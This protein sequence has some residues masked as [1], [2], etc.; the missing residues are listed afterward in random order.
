MNIAA[1]GLED[2]L[3]PVLERMRAA[4]AAAPMPGADERRDRLARLES[5]LTTNEHALVKAMSA[6]FAHRSADECRLFDI[7]VPLGGIRFARRNLHRWMRPRRVTTPLHLRPAKSFLQPQPKGVAGI[8]AP[9]NFPILLLVAPAASAIAAGNRV[10]LK[11]SEL[12]PRTS[13]LLVEHLHRAFAED[14]LRVITGGPEIGAAFSSLPFDHLFFTGS[15][16]VGRK[17]AE[18]A[19]RNLTPVTLELGGKSP[20]V[21]APSADLDLAARRIAFGKLSNAGQACI[22]VDYVLVPRD[23]MEPFSAKLMAAIDVLYP[24]GL[25]S[26]DYSAIISDRHL[27]RLRGLIDEAEASGARVLRPDWGP[28]TGRKLTPAVVVDPDPAL[29]VMREEVFGPVLSVLPYDTQE[30]ALAF[31]TARDHPLA[32]YLFAQDKKDR[33]IWARQ[34]ISGGLSV[35]EVLF[36]FASETLPFGGIGA[37][38][39]GAAHGQV[40]FDAFSHVKPVFV[41]RRPNWGFAFAPPFTGFKR[42]FAR[43]ARRIM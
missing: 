13:D 40:G 19:G 25:G 38:G 11:P 12:S 7:T 14:E 33:E 23:L 41:Q 18:A 21:I 36:H 28:G 35:N 10:M 16:V 15:T 39:I 26:P 2:S 42:A 43:I 24:D 31:V 17:V 9:W 5:V 32:L 22:G 4:Q 27:D 20:A 1:S 30:D 37:S 29:G 6:D 8:V 3:L 34:S